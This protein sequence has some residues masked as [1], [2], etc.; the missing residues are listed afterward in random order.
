MQHSNA[1]TTKGR[2]GGVSVSASNGEGAAAKG[3]VAAVAD[4]SMDGIT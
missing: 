2:A 1:V 4:Y 3:V